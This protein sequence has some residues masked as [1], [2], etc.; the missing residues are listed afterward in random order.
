MGL[1]EGRTMVMQQVP[2]GMLVAQATCAAQ[3]RRFS[4]RL[5]LIWPA[6]TERRAHL[7]GDG[8]S[9]FLAAD[10]RVPGD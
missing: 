4:R 8:V 9:E 2:L 5:E 1:A 3:G 10:D 6:P 7:R